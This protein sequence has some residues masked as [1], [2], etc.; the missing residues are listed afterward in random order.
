M[1][2]VSQS[3]C[4]LEEF[5]KITPKPHDNF[6]QVRR[7]NPSMLASHF[8]EIENQIALSMKPNRNWALHITNGALPRPRTPTR[9]HLAPCERCSHYSYRLEISFIGKMLR[10]ICHISQKTEPNATPI[11]PSIERLRIVNADGLL[12]RH[13][14][15][16]PVLPNPFSKMIGTYHA[17]DCLARG[18]R[19]AHIGIKI[20]H[21]YGVK[22]CAC[23]YIK[24]KF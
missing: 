4:W 1:F 12:C 10:P 7:R 18:M 13:I 11:D 24:H 19:L 6:K 17:M 2:A 5:E 16:Q 15:R 22:V 23:C 14:M 20:L 21:E 3:D 9:S 8:S